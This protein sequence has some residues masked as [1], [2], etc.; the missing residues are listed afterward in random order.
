[1]T[2]AVTFLS[3][4]LVVIGLL[5]SVPESDVSTMTEQALRRHQTDK[6]IALP[7]DVLLCPLSPS[8]RS[9]YSASKHVWTPM[10]TYET[11]KTFYI[12]YHKKIVFLSLLW[13]I[14]ITYKYM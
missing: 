4:P 7:S 3:L 1:M 2:F 5:A 13:T 12:K 9:K 8:D 10:D 6:H 14:V 11:L